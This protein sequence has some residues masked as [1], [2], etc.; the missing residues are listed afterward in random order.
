MKMIKKIILCA[1]ILLINLSVSVYANYNYIYTFKAF[2]LTRDD[3]PITFN[4][5][6]SID[7]GVYTNKDIVL[8][9]DFS[10]PI[11]KI[12]GFEISEDGKRLTKTIGENESQTIVV[13]DISGNRCEIPYSINNIDKI[14]PEIIGV[15]SGG[16]Y[17]RPQTI[18]YADNVGIKDIYID[19]Y[20]SLGWTVYDDYYDTDYYKG[21]DL[22]SNSILVH[23]SGHPKNTYAYKY[24]LNGNLKAQTDQT[25]YKFTGLNPG[26]NYEVKV[27]A[28]DKNGS[29][30]S[31]ITSNVK[32]KYFKEI[33]AEKQGSNFKVTLY[34]LDSKVTSALAYSYI[35]TNNVKYYN[36]GINPDRSL[37]MNFSANDLTPNLSNGYYYFHIRLLNNQN[38][39]ETVCCNVIF[40]TTYKEN[41]IEIDPYNLIQT[42][43]YQII[44]TDLAGNSTT[45]DITIN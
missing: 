22:T 7:D 1:T 17:K 6:K 38:I 36:V 28:I 18:N 35:T 5:R 39:I 19:R 16:K 25:K 14:P 29:V 3:I 33:Q 15:E 4:I 24:Y 8:S 23:L 41:I 2:S 20:T 43:N 32:T 34:G 40:N 26:T 31:K 42:G 11:D 9:I 10:K 12:E 44:V 45:K 30:L 37:T 21:I 13:E 27:E